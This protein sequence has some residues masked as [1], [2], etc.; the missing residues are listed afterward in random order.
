MR[1]QNVAQPQGQSRRVDVDMP[2]GQSLGKFACYSRRLWAI[3]HP[4]QS[5]VVYPSERGSAQCTALEKNRSRGCRALKS[6]FLHCAWLRSWQLAQS[7]SK[8]LF[9]WM[10][11]PSPRNQPIPA[12][13]SNHRGRVSGPLA[14]PALFVFAHR[15][16]AI[17]HLPGHHDFA[18]AV[19]AAYAGALRND[20]I[21]RPSCGQHLFLHCFLYLWLPLVQNPCPSLCRWKNPFQWN[22]PKPANT[23]DL[24]RFAADPNRIGCKPRQTLTG[25]VAVNILFAPQNKTQNALAGRAG[26]DRPA[27]MHRPCNMKVRIC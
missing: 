17:C 11:Q 25:N 1:A 27:P 10:N 16:S 3:V 2:Q 23:S 6:P 18:T 7:L 15:R 20:K 12:S 24:R 14:R 9:M 19:R 26:S 13:T 4:D 21:W 8:K 22:Q 5:K